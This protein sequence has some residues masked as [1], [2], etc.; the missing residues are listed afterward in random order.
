MREHSS[1]VRD[2][3]RSPQLSNG[4]GNAYSDVIL[5]AARLSPLAMTLR[6]SEEEIARLHAAVRSTLELWIDRLRRER[7]RPCKIV[8]GFPAWRDPEELTLPKLLAMPLVEPR[9]TW[10]LPGGGRPVRGRSFAGTE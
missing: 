4:N 10:E 9:N 7:R 6:L 2:N 3:G 8:I 5:H 1:S